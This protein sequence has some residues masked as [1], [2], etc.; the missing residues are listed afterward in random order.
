MSL[1][2]SAKKRASR[3]MSCRGARG[4]RLLVALVIACLGAGFSPGKPASPAA[5]WVPRPYGWLL[6]AEVNRPHSDHRVVEDEEASGQK[7][8]W[9]RTAWQP[10]AMVP[11]L[12]PDAPLS[13]EL[14]T[15]R[16]G[17]AV[18]LKALAADGTQRESGWSW[19]APERWTWERGGVFRREA[20]EHGFLVIR[21]GD[22]A[23]ATEL[24][25]VA[26]VTNA[27]LA[28]EAFAPPPMCATLALDWDAPAA[29]PLTARHWA[30]NDY[31]LLRAR[32]PSAEFDALLR[33][34]DPAV[35]R[36]HNAGLVEA[37][38]DAASRGWNVAAIRGAFARMPAYKDV[39][40]MVNIN[41]W[42]AWFHD[43]PVLPENLHKPFAAL[44]ADLARIFREEL[45]RPVAYWELLN[46][47][48]SRYEQAGALPSL[49]RLLALIMDEIRAVDPDA[50]I[51][52]PALTWPKPDWVEGFLAGCGDRIDFFSWHSYASGSRDDSTTHILSERVDA[53]CNM[54]KD[55][56][57]RLARHV[58]G[59]RVETF[60]TEYNI[61]WTW[62]TRDPRMANHVGAIFQA[63]V[64]TGLAERGI[65]GAFV[66]HFKDNIYGLVD[67][68]N[69]PRPAYHFFRQAGRYLV[70]DVLPVVL[71][72]P[73]AMQALAVRRPDGSRSL[74]LVNRSDTPLL[75]PSPRRL[76]ASSKP[77]RE[78]HIGADRC[79]EVQP[80]A[81]AEAPFLLP[82]Y[83]LHLFLLTH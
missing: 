69:N 79:S 20:L 41:N 63:L 38:S 61:S 48:D 15:R 71:S 54:A 44:C 17:G 13:F 76:L 65:D 67:L 24:D 82:P 2:E 56:R 10:L 9:S 40:I 72:D 5:K 21:D 78:F 4:R 53:V 23:Q 42:P 27:V 46:E 7:A 60:L 73:S 22:V 62:E 18:C 66:W 70:G 11:A 32:E 52:G 68:Q 29:H 45:K 59:K 80:V 26:I 81:N 74:L 50:R 1:R 16:R 37:W 25:A 8:I 75:L 49:W 28:A 57:E 64:V 36:I 6:E 35:I 83:S 43:G 55:A 33:D 3:R 51:G 12:P 30:I 14:W 31:E 58:P 77:L 34:L 19:G 47:Q 39:P